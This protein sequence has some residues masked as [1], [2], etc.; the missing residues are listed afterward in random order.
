MEKRDNLALQNRA[1][2]NQYIPAGDEIQVREG[3]INEHILARKNA[4]VPDGFVN[5]VIA[6]HLG[7]KAAKT[8]GLNVLKTVFR[9]N[10][11]VRAFDADIADVG[12][13][14]LC[15]PV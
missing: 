6:I 13:K 3:R 15:Q 12:G 11:V 2:V 7:E 5:L 8:L 1:E 4:Q 14:N 9:I 10:P